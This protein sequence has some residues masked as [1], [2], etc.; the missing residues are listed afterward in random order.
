MSLLAA[1]FSSRQALARFCFTCPGSVLY[2]STVLCSTVV[3]VLDLHLISCA[4]A[5]PH[6]GDWTSGQL[7]LVWTL[8]VSSA[9]DW[10]CLHISLLLLP[11]QSWSSRSLYRFFQRSPPPT[12]DRAGYSCFKH[13]H[14]YGNTDALVVT[15]QSLHLGNSAEGR[16]CQPLCGKVIGKAEGASGHVCSMASAATI[17]GTFLLLPIRNWRQGNTTSRLCA[18]ALNPYGILDP[19]IWLKNT[20]VSCSILL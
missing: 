8:A 20:K 7:F 1:P 19:E 5:H 17:S 16:K 13:A 14:R 10:T 3:L 18:V 11:T 2:C 15:Q 12:S 4:Q 6:P 9:I